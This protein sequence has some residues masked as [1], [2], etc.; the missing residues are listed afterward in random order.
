MAGYD[1][2]G[3]DWTVSPEEARRRVGPNVTVQG[4]LDPC[5]LYAPK[6]RFYPRHSNV[7]TFCNSNNSSL[8]QTVTG[9]KI[10]R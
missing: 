10:F 4:N 9:T 8:K 2:V 5:A 3:I 6:V 7:S 1:I